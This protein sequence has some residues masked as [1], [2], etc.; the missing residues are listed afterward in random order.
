[1]STTAI[2]HRPW[3]LFTP[4]IPIAVTCHRTQPVAFEWE[5][6]HHA[7]VRTRGPERIESG[8]WRGESTRR[9][10]Y[11]VETGTGR[12]HWIYRDLNTGHWHLHG[13]C[14]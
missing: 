3:R 13:H 14:E 10:Y 7:I 8:W 12:R 4:P 6:Q 9:D 5:D 1:V 11:R 2:G